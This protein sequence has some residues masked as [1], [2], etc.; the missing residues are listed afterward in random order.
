[1]YK[2]LLTLFLY[3]LSTTIA[4]AQPVKVLLY[5]GGATVFEQQTVSAGQSSVTLELPQVAT[6]QALRASLTGTS[7]AA[8]RELEYRSVLPAG[9]QSPQ[10]EAKIQELEKTLKKLENEQRAHQLAVVYWSNQ[11]P[12][13][14]A[15]PA[16]AQQLAAV[17]ISESNKQLDE[18]SRL[19]LALDKV[20][21]EL[22]EAQRQLAEQSGNNKRVWQVVI[23]FSA[24]LAADAVVVYNYPIHQAGWHSEYNI[25]AVPASAA[26]NWTW[27]AVIK[28][29][30]GLDWPAVSV[31]IATR[32]P[33][34]S[35]TP[36]ENYDWNIYQYTDNSRYAKSSRVTMDA[37]VPEMDSLAKSVVP[38][39]VMEP[40]R[41]EG[42]IFDMYEMGTLTLK[43][44]QP[45]RI[46]VRQGSWPAHFSYL[47]R[48]QQ[49]TDAFLMAHITI[50]KDV[51]A[52]PSGNAAI[53]LEG[54]YVGK[55]PFSLTEKQD[56]DISFGNDPALVVKVKTDHVA[57][58]KGVISKSKTYQWNW[59]ISFINTKTTAV[60]LR[61]ED[62]YPHI[63][64][65]KIEVEELFSEPLPTKKDDRISW[66][67]K[68]EA[69][70]DK[71]LKYGYQISYPYDMEINKGR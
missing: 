18:V 71:M 70:Q 20:K 66:E 30:S 32:E 7:P 19:Q 48:P 8:I 33:V 22:K 38:M 37:A 55:R 16:A 65:D 59:A 41:S 21:D 44:G 57:G 29:T 14:Q 36:P 17:I 49:S 27:D 47:V 25:N 67:F 5:P 11:K 61:V 13:P 4:T 52:L 35:L 39:A 2:Y 58:D 69:G 54:V 24:P 63:G 45:V 62:S 60:D 64:H 1:M 56:M 42:Q 46:N 43:S 6:P 34:F 12:D 28:Q 51:P 68:L 26:V 10:L 23:S 31:A 40:V 3:V 50:G 9:S 53:Q 15:T